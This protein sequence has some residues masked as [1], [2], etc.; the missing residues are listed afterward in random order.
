MQVAISSGVGLFWGGTHLTELS[1]GDALQPKPVVRPLLEA[2]FG[3]T[4]FEQ[5]LVEEQPGEIA[6]EG[7]PGPIGALLSRGEAANCEPGIRVTEM[8]NRRI[9]PVGMLFPKGLAEADQTWA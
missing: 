4:E 7:P 5:G 8:R 6:G 1:D 3:K 9:P 2:P